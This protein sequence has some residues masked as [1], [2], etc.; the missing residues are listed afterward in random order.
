M[1][2]MGLWNWFGGTMDD[3]EEVEIEHDADLDATDDALGDDSEGMD[4]PDDGPDLVELEHR[5][6]EL[7]DG[8]ERN[9]S[10]IENVQHSQQEVAERVEEIND[11]VR[12]LLGVY[13]Q[14]TD[15]V[16]PFTDETDADPEASGFGVVNAN[17]SDTGAHEE[18]EQDRSVDDPV[19]AEAGNGAGVE[20]PDDDLVTFED[21]VAGMDESAESAEP[22]E[23]S[24][25]VE[26]E[27]NESDRPV[28]A[29]AAAEPVPVGGEPT[30][31]ERAEGASDVGDRDE[32]PAGRTPYLA[33]LPDGYAVDVLVF[34]WLGELVETAGP[35]AALKAVAY[36]EDIDW[37]GSSVA[38]TLD[39]YLSGPGIDIY[40]DPN[41]PDD[42]TAEDHATS[43]EYI[44]KLDAIGDLERTT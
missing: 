3:D 28:E 36:Y 41:E 42:L 14:L 11:V 27:E 10:R 12:D 2:L 26:D 32:N 4:A 5:V 15:D 13:D 35:A 1:K 18:P 23:A 19:P 21:V 6:G 22:T 37:I 38:A 39:E 25:P 20:D 40:V 17:G 8:L 9:E 31:T 30:A 16:N 33:D 44:L 7:G 29:E 34:E 24:T 43:Y